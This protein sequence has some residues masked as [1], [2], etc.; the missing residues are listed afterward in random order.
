ME[1]LKASWPPSGRKD[2]KTPPSWKQVFTEWVILGGTISYVDRRTTH[3]WGGGSASQLHTC[4]KKVGGVVID[5][6]SGWGR[7][8]SLDEVGEGQLQAPSLEEGSLSVR[9]QRDEASLGAHHSGEGPVLLAAGY[10][11][12]GVRGDVRGM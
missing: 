12:S 2:Q 1:T 9:I 4:Y 11:G 10:A 5:K 7:G 3:S 6:A 8:R